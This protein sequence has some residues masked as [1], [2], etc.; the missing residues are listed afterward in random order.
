M[1]SAKLRLAAAA[2]ARVPARTLDAQRR[3]L[4]A[5]G[6][7]VQKAGDAAGTGDYLEAKAALQGTKAQVTQ[8]LNALEPPGAQSTR[9]PG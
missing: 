1:A 7:S 2:R 8:V 3:A 4:A 6:E 5:V 9:R